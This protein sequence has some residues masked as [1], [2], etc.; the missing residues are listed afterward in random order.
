MVLDRDLDIWD[1]IQHD[2]QNHIH[3]RGFHEGIQVEVLRGLQGTW[4]GTWTFK[5]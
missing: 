4:I 2:T 5:T 1:D 3:F